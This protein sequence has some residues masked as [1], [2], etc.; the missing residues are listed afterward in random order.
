MQGLFFFNLKFKKQTHIQKR[1][2]EVFIKLLLINR[3]RIFKMY[4]SISH[5][6]Q[7]ILIILENKLF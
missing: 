5:K 2:N 4:M 7:L 1:G 3:R 6:S